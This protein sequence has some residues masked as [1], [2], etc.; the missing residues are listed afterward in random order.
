MTASP[1][2]ADVEAR[3]RILRP[4]PLS[5][6]TRERLLGAVRNPRAPIAIGPWITGLSTAA[7][8]AIAIGVAVATRPGEPTRDQR[9]SSAAQAQDIERI[10]ILRERRLD[11]ALSTIHPR[12]LPEAPRW[13]PGTPKPWG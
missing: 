8:V 2:D 1:S 13:E 7:V 12:P 6:Q 9:E 4:R 10:M 11:K 3:L 5:G